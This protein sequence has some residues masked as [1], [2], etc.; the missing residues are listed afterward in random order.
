MRMQ[1][2]NQR[3]TSCNED[4]LQDRTVLFRNDDVEERGV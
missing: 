1:R 2:Y 3:G 4:K